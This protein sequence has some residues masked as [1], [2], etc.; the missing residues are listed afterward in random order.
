MIKKKAGRKS[1]RPS[2]E[3]FEAL[4]SAF[5]AP[6]LAE[7]LEVSVGT[8]YQWANQFR[9]EENE[10]LGGSPCQSPTLKQ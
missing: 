8:I 9:R 5:S 1:K 10:S 2:K 3:Q 6:E 4:Y 7:K